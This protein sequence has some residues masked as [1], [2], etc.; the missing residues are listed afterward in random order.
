VKRYLDKNRLRSASHPPYSPSEC[1]AT[2]LFG[3]VKR[4]PPGTESQTAEEFLEAVI[5]ILSDIPRDTL[6]VIFHQWVER[7]QACIDGH[8]DCVE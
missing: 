5:Q 3:H 4:M 8:E 2:F 7:L 1:R 6:M